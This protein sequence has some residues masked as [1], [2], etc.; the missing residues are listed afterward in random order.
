MKLDTP[1]AL[2][3]G[4]FL[5]RVH[6]GGCAIL[7][8][9]QSGLA[10]EPADA[11]VSEY[12]D[13]IIRPDSL[14]RHATTTWPQLWRWLEM[15]NGRVVVGGHQYDAMVLAL[16]WAEVAPDDMDESDVELWLT[17]PVRAKHGSGPALLM[18]APKGLAI[19]LPVA[20][21]ALP[22]KWEPVR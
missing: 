10:V 8:T 3:D 19:V 14:E 16:A 2:P 15:V 20:S 1:Y 17:K 12:L 13:G 21:M 22:V 7:N 5:V 9:V 4:R 18:R 6:A 11:G